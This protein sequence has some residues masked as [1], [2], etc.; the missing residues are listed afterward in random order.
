LAL[1][2]KKSFKLLDRAKKV[3]PAQTHTFSRGYSCF[4]EGH[5]PVFASHGKG[6]HFFDVDGNEFIDYMAALGP[7][8]LGYSNDNVNQKIKNQIDCGTVF[9]LP[10]KLEVEAAELMCKLIPSADMAK[11]S[12]TGSDSVTA[13]VRASRAITKKDHVAYCGGGGVW[14]D[15]F[16]SITS[17]NLGVPKSLK[18]MVKVF[19]YNNIESLKELLDNDEKIGTVCMEPM[20][21]EYPSKNFLQDV[22]RITHQHDA[23]LIFDEVQTGFR[24]SLGGAEQYFKIKPDLSAWGKAM[25]NGVPIGSIT[26]K[27]EFMKIFEDIFYS[28]T[29][30]GESLSLAGFIA[31]VDEIKKTKA[32]QKIHSK[33]KAFSTEFKKL[34][35][36]SNAPITISGFPAKLKLTFEDELQN[37]SL[38]MRSVFCQESIQK[39]IFFWQGPLFITSSHSIDD[40]SKTLNA[41]EYSINI[42][43][44]AKN[45]T[46]LKKLLKGPLMK[47][48]LKFPV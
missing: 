19:E 23:L 22:K 15:W 21:F 29:F 26:G 7:I 28:T 42:L 8:I 1:T 30:A 31:T 41:T 18:K 10:H 3:L 14:H 35:K 5:Y 46:Q 11:F 27:Q 44:S 36:R 4:I 17:K 20:T 37:D 2:F 40:F 45:P 24:W 9:S 25:G 48:V 16:T 34:C 6:S 39:G 12:K 43:N 38:L 47:K 33:G 32:I 13:A